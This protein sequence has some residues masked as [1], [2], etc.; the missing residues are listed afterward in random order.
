MQTIRVGENYPIVPKE[1]GFVS[2][3]QGEAFHV[4]GFTNNIRAS[5]VRAFKSNLLRYGVF[6][7]GATDVGIA[8]FFLIK[9]VGTD[10][11]FDV[12][13]N[14]PIEAEIT[15]DHFLGDD[16]GAIIPLILCDYPGGKVRAIRAISVDAN[17]INQIRDTCRMQH[18]AQVVDA[19]IAECYMQI[20]LDD[21][22]NNTA[23]RQP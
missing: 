9:I 4:V 14:L 21:M 11:S 16:S 18:D 19:A 1:E 22:I 2:R 17:T 5:E 3:L 23:M 10:W 6:R 12:S 7:Y 8:P 15:R 20:S 13:F